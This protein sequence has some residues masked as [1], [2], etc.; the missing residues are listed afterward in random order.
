MDLQVTQFKVSTWCESGE[1]FRLLSYFIT[2]L[3]SF[4]RKLKSK[5]WMCMYYVEDLFANPVIK[6]EREGGHLPQTPYILDPDP[7]L[8]DMYRRLTC[9]A[10]A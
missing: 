5:N 7:S 3:W 2:K 1:I 4:Y 8:Q 9:T 6:T 10:I